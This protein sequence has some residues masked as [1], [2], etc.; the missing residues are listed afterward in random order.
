LQRHI[1]AHTGDKHNKH[2]IYKVYH[3][4]VF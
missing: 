3:L 2:H 1:I 4:Y